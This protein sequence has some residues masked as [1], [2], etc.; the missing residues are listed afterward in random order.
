MLLGD[1][2]ERFGIGQ[3]WEVWESGEKAGKPTQEMFSG[4][5][6]LAFK[7]ITEGN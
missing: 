5:Q 4:L 7:M 1:I 6:T 3:V 2:T